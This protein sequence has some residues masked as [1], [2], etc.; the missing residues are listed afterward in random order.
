MLGFTFFIHFFQNVIVSVNADG[1]T[2]K[3]VN[4]SYVEPGGAQP[5]AFTFRGDIFHSRKIAAVKARS[6]KD[7]V[8]VKLLENGRQAQVSS[9]YS[10]GNILLC[11]RT[12]CKNVQ[13]MCQILT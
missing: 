7:S 5:Y 1:G 13:L 12:C 11:D 4:L 10:N 3:P 6:D 9:N 8:V 2:S